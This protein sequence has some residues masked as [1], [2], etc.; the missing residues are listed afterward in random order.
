M[1]NDTENRILGPDGLPIA[2]EPKAEMDEAAETPDWG[3]MPIPPADFSFLIYSLT[4]QAQIQLGLLRIDE[5]EPPRAN[6]PIA[7]H[8]IDILS[9][10]QEK[11]RGNLDLQEKLLLENTLTDLRFRYVQA[12]Q[13]SKKG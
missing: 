12:S 9:M 4:T 11:T 10:L 1:A 7:R 2:P 5:N 3:S 13:E 8:T 6:L